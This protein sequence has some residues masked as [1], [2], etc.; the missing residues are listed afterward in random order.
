M[1]SSA[2]WADW[3]REAMGR[4]EPVESL[5]PDED[6]RVNRMGMLEIL[7]WQEEAKGSRGTRAPLMG[8]DAKVRGSP[9]SPPRLVP[10]SPFG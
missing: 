6:V 7:A 3:V 8:R 2:A 5:A 4:L 10:R 9:F 1:P